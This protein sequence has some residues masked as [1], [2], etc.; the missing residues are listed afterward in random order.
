[1]KREL[2]KLETFLTADYDAQFALLADAE[3]KSEVQ[4]WMGPD[5]FQQFFSHAPSTASHLGVGPK[6]ILFAPGVM[7]STLQS[8]G[9][10]GVWWLDLVRTRD[11]L[12]EL[13][14]TDDG[15][16][17]I[18]EDAD[19]QPGAVDLSYVPFRKAI[20]TSGNF[21]GSIQ[22][23]YDWRKS[24]RSSVDICRDEINRVFD[25]YQKPVHLVGHSMG[26][27]MIRETLRVHGKELWKKVGRIVFIGTPHYGSTSI[28]GYL[29]N[30]L[31]GW[32]QVGVLAMFLSRETFRSLRGVLSLLP[33][34]KGI[35]PGTRNGQEHP[36]ANFDMY[37]A[38]AWKLGLNASETVKLQNILDEVKQFYTDLYNWHAS[39]LQE[40]KDR[41]LMLAGVGQETLFRLEFDTAFW[42]LWEKTKKITHVTPC[43]VNRDGD[44]RVPLASAELE[45]VT[46]RYVVGE[47]GGLPNI[48]SVARD[49]LTWLSGGSSSDLK[50]SKTCAG[51]QKSHL[52]A[53]DQ[54]SAAPLLE[55]STTKSKF[56]D[57]PDYENP[58]P[59]FRAK[60]EADLEAGR[61]PQINL[62]KIL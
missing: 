19:V 13:R 28:A 40:Y 21:G 50:L 18:D 33:A 1:M 29:K 53:E 30:H 7:G 6:N 35:Y 59:E 11:K 62:V 31:W 46:I 37:D 54:A 14:L 17:E 9:L 5:A 25:D 32:E 47:H 58:T 16:H 38:Q 23:P 52:S 34:P 55:G 24:F 48:P 4:A 44:G 45:D 61:I 57:L 51:A 41:M 12:N 39:L 15:K 49:T 3:T 22:F 27:L 10:G 43:D 56:R 60:I 26:G 42:G 36:C 20:A 2:T 8:N